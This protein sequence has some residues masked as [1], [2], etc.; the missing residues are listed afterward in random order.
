VL[1]VS[2]SKARIINTLDPMCV[3]ENMYWLR[4]IW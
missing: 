3:V 1:T 2:H 4:F